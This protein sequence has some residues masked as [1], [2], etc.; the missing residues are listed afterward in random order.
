MQGLSF[1]FQSL[2]ETSPICRT[3]FDSFQ[4][5]YS[6]FSSGYNCMV[7][8]NAVQYASFLQQIAPNWK[9]RRQSPLVNAGYASR[10][11]SMTHSISSFCNYHEFAHAIDKTT[12]QIVLLGCGVDV[13]GLWSS[14]LVE[15]NAIRIIEIDMP[16]ICDIKRKVT[17]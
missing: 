11:L 7:S 8:Q 10:V 6:A 2:S 12:I 4:A 14:S 16:E 5:K 13:V 9:N 3:A 15:T 17:C 1:S